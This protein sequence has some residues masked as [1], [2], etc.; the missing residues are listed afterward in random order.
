MARSD[1]HREAIKCL[2]TGKIVE[3]ER[4]SIQPLHQR[5]SKLAQISENARA[6]IDLTVYRSQFLSRDAT[7]GRRSLRIAFV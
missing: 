3:N 1:T 4:P 6:R 2:I 5:A 7:W